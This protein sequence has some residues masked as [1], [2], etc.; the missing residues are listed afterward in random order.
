MSNAMFQQFDAIQNA[1]EEIVKKNKAEKASNISSNTEDNLRPVE[2]MLAKLKAQYRQLHANPTNKIFCKT[3]PKPDPPRRPAPISG[4]EMLQ[5]MNSIPSYA[6]GRDTSLPIRRAQSPM[7]RE[8][9]SPKTSIGNASEKGS[10]KPP[11]QP[12]KRKP[13]K[14]KEPYNSNKP[15]KNQISVTMACK[16]LGLKDYPIPINENN[17]NFFTNRSN[18][19]DYYLPLVASVNMG[20]NPL[21]IQTLVKAKWFEVIQAKL[22]EYKSTYFNKPRR[23]KV[24]VNVLL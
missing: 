24:K 1:F 19:E 23:N 11:T 20:A 10:C 15:A 4:E 6:R 22:G 13:I 21:S 18:F 17:R 2:N 9:E 16:F 14:K 12:R 5:A 3:L 7:C 8:G